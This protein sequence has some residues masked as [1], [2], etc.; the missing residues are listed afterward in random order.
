MQ[1][2][3]SA[4]TERWALG[5]LL[6]EGAVMPDDTSEPAPEEPP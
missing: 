2:H 4:R 5:L 3:E 1:Q 6:P